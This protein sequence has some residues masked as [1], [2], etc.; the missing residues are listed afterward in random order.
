MVELVHV[1][2]VSVIVMYHL[3]FPCVELLKYVFLP[4]Y[5]LSHPGGSQGVK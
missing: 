5:V 2:L 3:L 1:F 4:T